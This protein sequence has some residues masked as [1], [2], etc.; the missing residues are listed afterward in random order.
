MST[1]QPSC[2]DAE[3]TYAVNGPLQRQNSL[4]VVARVLGDIDVKQ[5]TIRSQRI[6]QREA[7]VRPWERVERD[8]GEAFREQ[9]EVLWARR[10]DGCRG[11]ELTYSTQLLR[12]ESASDVR[13]DV[14]CRGIASGAIGAVSPD[15]RERAVVHVCET[16]DGY[17]SP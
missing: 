6:V 5:S 2:I 9:I 7:P 13:Y 1:Q 14:V 10:G 3:R 11:V 8:R 16:W 17:G 15:E 12:I 4:L